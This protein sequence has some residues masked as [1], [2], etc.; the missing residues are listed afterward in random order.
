LDHGPR[1]RYL[2]LSATNRK[3]A[4]TLETALNDYRRKERA[5][6]GIESDA[7]LE[8]FV[9]QL[10][11]STRRATYVQTMRNRA[12]AAERA[13]PSSSF[14]DP[15]LGAIFHGQNG[16][17]E[18][19]FWL[20]FLAIHFGKARS[21]QWELCRAVYGRLGV[22]PVATWDRTRS[23]VEDLC[24]WIDANAELIKKGPPTRRFGNHRKYEPLIGKDDS[25]GT[26]SAIR[27][28]V[29][30]VSRAGSHASLIEAAV[31]DARGDKY[32][33]FD[34]LYKSMS[35]VASFGRLAK[36]DY[37]SMLGKLGLAPIAAGSTYLSSSTGPLAGAALLFAGNASAKS[38]PSTMD[39]WLRKLGE[40]LQVT[41]QDL[42]DALCNWQKSPNS[43][44][45]FRG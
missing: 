26:P 25:R 16:N 11:D 35:A 27:S 12:I 43:Y 45:R 10:V 14:F 20:T 44:K 24:H 3:R 30:W 7:R 34:K 23:N 17:N 4:F 38:R 28:Y 31:K 39:G 36:F 21:S 41:M 40:S 15:I 5:L 32:D 19:A 1:N 9:C 8:A 6:P 22:G 29:G 13:D 42:E 18:E 37:L 33:A 2:Q